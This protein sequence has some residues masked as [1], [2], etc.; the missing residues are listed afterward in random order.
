MR[1]HYHPPTGVWSSLTRSVRIKKPRLNSNISIRKLVI[2]FVMVVL[3]LSTMCIGDYLFNFPLHYLIIMLD[4]LGMLCIRHMG[5]LDYGMDMLPFMAMLVITA[6]MQFLFAG[7]YYDA[8]M[9][10]ST[11]I[12]LMAMLICII[13]VMQKGYGGLIWKIIN[14]FN[15]VSAG[16]ILA[17][18]AFGFVGIRLDKLGLISDFLFNAWEFTASF[19]QCGPY[20]EPAIFA[21]PA[22]LSLFYYLFIGKNLKKATV[23]ILALLFSTSALALMGILLLLTAW[24]F[25]SDKLYG[26]SRKLKWTILIVAVSALV[27]FL[28]AALNADVFIV[29]RLISGSSIG[30]RALRSVD[31][32]LEM[33]P[34]EKITGIGLQ[35]QARYLNH[36]GITLA[37]DTYETSIF[38]GN[39]E[40]AG[41]LGYILC[42]TGFFG[43]VF[44]VRP[45]YRMFGRYGL[46]VKVLCLL[47]LYVTLFCAMFGNSILVVYFLAVYS[48]VDLECSGA[49][50]QEGSDV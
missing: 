24:S 49:F 42:T 7:A 2:S 14:F 28:V 46:Q 27:V 26:V 4:V 18:T 30:V 6:V 45:F 23:L 22:L 17:Q 48:T 19:R 3:I 43:L 41:S 34:L 29:E 16:C 1:S 36:Y 38:T 25:N 21:Q 5:D 9:V 12:L 13:F 47:L 50:V 31:L 10:I 11:V 33:S 37:H 32:F 40:Y 20:A 15:L 44:F 35:N 39:R 8:G